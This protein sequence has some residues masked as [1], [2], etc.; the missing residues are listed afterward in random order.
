MYQLTQIVG[1]VGRDAE[2]TY[3]PKGDAVAKF[4]VAVNKT[5]GKGDDRKTKTT[6]FRIT[7][8]RELAEV[9]SQYVKKGMLVMV[10]G[11]V[12]SSAWINQ[13][14]EAQSTLELTGDKVIFLSR[15]DAQEHE[16][17]ERPTGQ[18]TPEASD[19]PF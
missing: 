3:T 4:T 1:N 12:H 9:T 19:V 15:K 18:D 10:V 5:W 14:G 6:W 8:W 2:L 7:C 16:E 13:Q 17:S 11:E